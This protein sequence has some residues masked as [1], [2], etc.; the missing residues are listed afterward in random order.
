MTI[1]RGPAPPKSKQ[2][3]KFALCKWTGLHLNYSNIYKTELNDP[4]CKEWTKVK[5]S[6]S[7]NSPESTVRYQRNYTAQCDK[8]LKTFVAVEYKSVISS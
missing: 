1:R 3:P 8:C 2:K 4:V 5:K 6:C 7:F